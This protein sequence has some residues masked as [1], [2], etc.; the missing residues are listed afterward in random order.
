MAGDGE[1]VGF[2]GASDRARVL[3]DFGV[4]RPGSDSNCCVKVDLVNAE[5]DVPPAA[6]IVVVDILKRLDRV[7]S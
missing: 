3:F 7:D 5:V 4:V 1:R 2:A 6:L